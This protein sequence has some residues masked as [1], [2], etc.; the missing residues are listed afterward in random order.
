M[1]R[2]APDH[3]HEADAVPIE[4]FNDPGEVHKGSAEPVYL[5]DNDAVH[6]SRLD[7]CQETLQ[8]RAI[9]VAAG[10][11][12]IVETIGDQL[13]TFVLLADDERLGSFPL[14]IQGVELLLEPLLGRLARVD[15]A[16]DDAL[17]GRLI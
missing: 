15:R 2:S 6:G 5:I 9:H 8:C 13:P 3:R 12:A 4:H 11:A 17:F 16:A 1:R 14:G 10:V 7:R